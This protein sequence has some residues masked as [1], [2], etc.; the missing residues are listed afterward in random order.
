MVQRALVGLAPEGMPLKAA[1]SYAE[2]GLWVIRA[3]QAV[4]P[5]RA[6]SVQTQGC[7]LAACLGAGR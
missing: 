3:I 1:P 2:T 7:E 6:R 4:D 5:P